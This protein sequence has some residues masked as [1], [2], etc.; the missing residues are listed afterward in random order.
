M[1]VEVFPTAQEESIPSVR[2]TWDRRGTVRGAHGP[3]QPNAL[4]TGK[5]GHVVSY[6]RKDNIG[7]STIDSG[8]SL[9]QLYDCNA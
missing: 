8:K 6:L 1:E 7:P 9:T 2:T 3:R 5:V 4:T